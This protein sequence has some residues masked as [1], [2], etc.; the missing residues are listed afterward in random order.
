VGF[1]LSPEEYR[2]ADTWCIRL[3][4]LVDRGFAPKSPV[5]DFGLGLRARHKEAAPEVSC[6][7][8]VL[9]ALNTIAPL[10]RYLVYRAIGAIDAPG[11][12]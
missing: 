12:G 1:L 4:E 6:R 9:H 7:G 10:A 3:P 5:A 2:E 11:A 8:D